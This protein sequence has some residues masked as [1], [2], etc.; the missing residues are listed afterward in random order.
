MARFIASL[1]LTFLFFLRTA[2]AQ[3]WHT[4]DDEDPAIEENGCVLEGVCGDFASDCCAPRSEVK[5][6]SD[7]LKPYCRDDDEYCCKYVCCES[8]PDGYQLHKPEGLEIVG[9]AAAVS[10]CVAIFLM[11]IVVTVETKSKAP[12]VQVH[13]IDGIHPDARPDAQGLLDAALLYLILCVLFWIIGAIVIDP[14]QVSC[15]ARTC[16][17]SYFWQWAFQL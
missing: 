14:G 9:V 5:A 13:G 12:G 17:S 7:G 16:N 4:M 8:A 3:E 15:R 2:G 1:L 10:I 6:C 11:G